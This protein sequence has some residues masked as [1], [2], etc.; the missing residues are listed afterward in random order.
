MIG[1]QKEEVKK[2]LICISDICE[3]TGPHSCDVV[4]I[5]SGL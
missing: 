1:M 5:Q 3:V 4:V 2:K